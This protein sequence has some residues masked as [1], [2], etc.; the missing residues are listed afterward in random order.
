MPTPATQRRTERPPPRGDRLELVVE[1]MA[2]GGAGVARTDRYV[3]FVEGAFPGERVQAEVTRAK[4]DYANARAVEILEPS[5]DRVPLRCD[6][7]GGECPGSPWQPLR[8]ERQLEYKHELVEDA[9]R[10]I[11]GFTDFEMEPIVP[12]ADPWRYRN[13]MEYTSVSPKTDGSFWGSMRV[14]GGTR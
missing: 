8:Y 6:H 11:G 4:R 12:A 10:R 1:R 13:K 14:G 7:E 2:H 9:L 3:V 5:P